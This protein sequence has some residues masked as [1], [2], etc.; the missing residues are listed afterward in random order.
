MRLNK[1]DLQKEL[2]NYPDVEKAIREEA[3]ER[4][5]I[6]TRRKTEKGGSDSS[7][8]SRQTSPSV[9]G[10][11]PRRMLNDDLDMDEMEA[12]LEAEGSVSK[13]RKPPDPEL[14]DAAASS[15]LGTLHIRQ[16]LRKLPLFKSL[17]DDILHFL[18]LNAQP[19]SY[20][21][22]TPIIT[23]GSHGREVFFICD[24]EVEVVR[25]ISGKD[26]VKARLGAG[27]YFGEV[28]SLSLSPQRTATVRTVVS[29]EC[30]TISG[31]VL[32]ELW[33]RCSSELRRQVE[34]TA[35]QR[36]HD[37][38]ADV[39]M[40]DPENGS[41][42]LDELAISSQ[43]KVRPPQTTSTKARATEPQ[44]TCEPIDPDPYGKVE[45]SIRRRPVSRR[46]SLAN[47][48]A[49]TSPLSGGESAKQLDKLSPRNSQTLLAPHSPSTSL[50][51]RQATP[52]RRGS[53]QGR[54]ILPENILVQILQHLSLADIMRARLTS[55]HWSKLI[56]TS[57]DLLHELNLSQF[58]RK[59]TD[60]VLVNHICPFVGH[61]PRLINI[62]NCYHITDEGFVALA[63]Y[64]SGNV[65]LLKMK[66][67]WDINAQ[68]IA[69]MVDRAKNIEEIDFSNCR[70]VSDSLLSRVV[71]WSVRSE[72]GSATPESKVV[73]CPKLSK[74]TLSYCK[75]ISDSSM[76][77]LAT[78]ASQR[79]R[80]LDLTRCTTISDIGFK[81]WAETSFP[82]L[83]KLTLADCTYLSDH[84][85]L[86]L[87]RAAKGLRE[88]DLVSPPDP[89]HMMYHH[90]NNPPQSFCCALSDA[91]VEILCR[92]CR[93]L[94]ILDLAFCGSAVSDASLAFI[95]FY[96]R[97]LRVLSVRG[98]VRVTGA[99]VE[100][101]LNCGGSG[102]PY[103]RAS[104]A[105]QHAAGA[106]KGGAGRGGAAQSAASGAG[107]AA[108][109]QASPTPGKS[110]PN[111]AEG[112]KIRYLEASQ[113]R[114][115]WPWVEAGGLKRLKPGVRVNTVADGRW[116]VKL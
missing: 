108:R 59:V 111:T 15:P 114:H 72:N 38:N 100:A 27:Q 81:Y 102:P 46:G 5:A 11:R 87:A 40:F 45:M 43:Q 21:P 91:A 52:Q 75:H 29:V 2:P 25:E 97:E 3:A 54:G 31:E 32:E 90:T 4:L 69:E 14:I 65:N 74:L 39:A 103:Q 53:R 106:G 16:T 37:G 88:L 96:L 22:F 13:K 7:R 82:R 28:T 104:P 77:I 33:S 42:A 41:L 99:G 71:G 19:R 55:V 51:P 47:F 60:T 62:N 24:G 109:A 94:R 35:R 116:R 23:Q 107:G 20:P 115:L 50:P 70:K 6:L 67:V 68:A 105:A 95:G 92:N 79:L 30:L 49:E 93:N 66:S 36:F 110:A 10:K 26:H 83:Q 58:N 57:P 34:A 44:G 84:A 18:G 12:K 73:G 48:P 61:R 8:A 76:H 1:E 80:H 98:C 89:L 9:N 64:C 101:V 86:S 112:S 85:I 113:C 17:P 56:A 78:Q 63:T